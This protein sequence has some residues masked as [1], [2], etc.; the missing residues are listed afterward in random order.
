MS[1]I[2]RKSKNIIAG[3][4]FVFVTVFCTFNDC[5]IAGWFVV[6]PPDSHRMLIYCIMSIMCFTD[7]FCIMAGLIDSYVYTKTKDIAILGRAFIF[8]SV[9]I[10]SIIVFCHILQCM[11]DVSFIWSFFL[12]LIPEWML[13]ILALMRKIESKKENTLL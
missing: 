1:K 11:L 10:A 4:Y 5:R 3:I 7:I 9:S 13:G 8:H 2:L 6:S 12:R